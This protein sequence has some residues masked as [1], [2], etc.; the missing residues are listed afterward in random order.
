M[1]HEIEE[2]EPAH[3]QAATGPLVCVL[4]Q[5]DSVSR[6]FHAARLPVRTFAS[7]ADFLKNQRH[8]GPCCLVLDVSSPE[9]DGFELQKE[10]ANRP[11]QLVFLTD[12]GDVAM[13]ARAMKA[14]AVD[15]LNKPADPA[16]L[17]EA[18]ARALTRSRTV[19]AAEARQDAARVKIASLTPREVAVMERVTAGML[20]KQIAAEL[21]SA[22]KTIKLHRG[23]MM[24]KTGVTSVADLVRL[25]LTAGAIEQDKA[26][27]VS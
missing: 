16:T 8:S 5:E 25:A 9:S 4:A 21:G 17:L 13:C 6:I 27:G 18:A 2:M 3:P 22:L 26:L 24:R 14:G 15:F 11:E 12:H 19:L 10:L 1:I 7:A 23:R 20:N